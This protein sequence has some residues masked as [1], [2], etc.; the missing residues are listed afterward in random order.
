[1]LQQS[2]MSQSF[3]ASLFETRP[4]QKVLEIKSQLTSILLQEK[5]A[6]SLQW[7]LK[8]LNPKPILQTASST[9]VDLKHNL[10]NKEQ[11]VESFMNFQNKKRNRTL[12]KNSRT[13]EKWI[14]ENSRQP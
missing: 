2:R 13:L 3:Q 1:M 6:Q 11:Q 8:H 10:L 12:L 9:R 4:N 14:W 7:A 5:Q